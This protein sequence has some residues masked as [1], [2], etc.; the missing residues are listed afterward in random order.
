M[1][2]DYIK[3]I[4]DK[5]KIKDLQEI[6]AL[7]IFFY[8]IKYRKK[9]FPD[10]IH[11]K[12]NSKNDP[13]MTLIFKYCYKLQRE[14]LGLLD[15][16]DYELY[17]KAQLLF[18]KHYSKKYSIQPVVDPIC[19][20]GEKAWKRWKKWKYEYKKLKN[21]TTN[22]NWNHNYDKIRIDLQKTKSLLDRLKINCNSS[23]II[24]LVTDS[25]FVFWYRSGEISPYFLLINK[26]IQDSFKQ[27]EL[28]SILK[29]DLGVYKDKIDNK[30]RT[31]YE[32]LF[33]FCR[34]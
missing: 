12:F 19:L 7:K 28:N 25:S 8:W 4:I 29:V 16:N 1:G 18:L 13:R 10:L 21:Y 24:K 9:V 17:V 15:E 33:E 30:I 23:D 3:I 22:N 34:S 11:S 14:T 27:I 26:I 32:E 20:V 5:Y 6:K 2:E 31:I